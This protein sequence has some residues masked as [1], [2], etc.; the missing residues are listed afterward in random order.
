M[1]YLTG[2]KTGGHYSIYNF[3]YSG[4]GPHQMLAAL[5]RGVVDQVVHEPVSHVIYQS[6]PAHVGRAAGLAQWDPH[7]PKYVLDRGGRPVYEGPFDGWQPRP[8]RWLHK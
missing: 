8:L 3:G 5:Q 1:P 6:I 7:G 4:Y 2:I